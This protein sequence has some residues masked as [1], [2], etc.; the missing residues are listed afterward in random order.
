MSYTC[1][2]CGHAGLR[3]PAY[4][5]HHSGSHEFCPCCHT[6]FGADDHSVLQPLEDTHC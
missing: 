4:N 3:E 6:E 1:P 2:I 5:T